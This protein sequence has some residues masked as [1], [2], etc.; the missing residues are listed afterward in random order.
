LHLL[1][2]VVLAV[3]LTV[4]FAITSTY[5]PFFG[6]FFAPL[7]APPSGVPA[8]S[9]SSILLALLVAVPGLLGGARPPGP[10]RGLF[11]ASAAV[12]LGGSVGAKAGNAPPPPAALLVAL[13]GVPVL[14]GGPLGGP[15][16][17]GLAIDGIDGIDGIAETLRGGP[18]GG[19]ARM[20]AG[21]PMEGVPLAARGGGGVAVPAFAA[22]GLSGLTHFFRSLS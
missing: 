5:R 18:I 2:L 12:T 22:S 3:I 10:P 15:I 1:S 13:A 4:Y 11:S 8:P 6:A 19:G 16:N 14:L 17:P 7:F 20:P 21:P 9:R